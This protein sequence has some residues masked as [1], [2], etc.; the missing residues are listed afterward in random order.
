M[1]TAA[2]HISMMEHALGATPDARHS[3]WDTLN[4]AGR[5]LTMWHDWSWRQEGFTTITFTAGQMAFDLP[6]DFDGIRAVRS[7]FNNPK[8]YIVVTPEELL[9]KKSLVDGPNS[10]YWIAFS[11]YTLDTGRIVPRGLIHPLPGDTND[12]PV[13]ILYRRGWYELDEENDTDFP[14][15][16]I[17]FER[18]LVLMARAF[19]VEYQ[20]QRPAMEDARVLAELERLRRNDITRQM[21]VGKLCG[22]AGSVYAGG[23]LNEHGRAI[24]E[25]GQPNAEIWP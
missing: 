16:P 2:Q 21:Q 3:L 20:T 6:S 12:P 18:A 7:P 14:R 9:H 11:T 19:A 22:G 17:E 15:I 10:L 4:E 8:T 1:K 24:I 25:M 23:G 5:A 13:T